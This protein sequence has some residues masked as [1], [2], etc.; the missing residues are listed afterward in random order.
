MQQRVRIVKPRSALTGKAICLTSSAKS[1]IRSTIVLKMAY[2]PPF[3]KSFIFYI[4]ENI[5]FR[6]K[7]HLERAS[8]KKPKAPFLNFF[9]LSSSP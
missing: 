3:R 4:S 7:Y 5:P 1:T 2:G 8:M 9:S 6:F